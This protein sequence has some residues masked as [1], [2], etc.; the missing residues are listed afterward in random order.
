MDTFGSVEK[1]VNKKTYPGWNPEQ[2]EKI[3]FS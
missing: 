2:V 3:P 1:D